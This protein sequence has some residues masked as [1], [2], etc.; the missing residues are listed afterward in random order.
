M[1]G[2]TGDVGVGHVTGSSGSGVDHLAPGLADGDD[3]QGIAGRQ[4]ADG[5]RSLVGVHAQTD[6]AVRLVV[7][8]LCRDR[9]R[10]NGAEIVVAF[11]DF[12]L[13][14]LAG[15]QE[16]GHDITALG[17]SGNRDVGPAFGRG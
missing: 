9:V 10:G 8:G 2:L 3:L 12:I 15:D 17:M 5:F 4:T 13:A 16:L 7:D 14:G 6:A 11:G 1:S